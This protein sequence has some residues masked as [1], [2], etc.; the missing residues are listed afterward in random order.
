VIMSRVD[1][2]AALEIGQDFG[3]RNFQGFLIDDMPAAKAGNAR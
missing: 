2:P 3:I 1:D